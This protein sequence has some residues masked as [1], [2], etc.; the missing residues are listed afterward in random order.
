MCIGHFPI[1]KYIDRP[2]QSKD[3]NDC[4]SLL[5]DRFMYDEERLRDL[6]AM[7]LDILNRAVG[8]SRVLIDEDDASRVAAFGLQV[9]ISDE[10]AERFWSG[11]EPFVGSQMLDLWKAGASPFLDEAGIARANAGQGVNLLTTHV[12]FRDESV[13][14]RNA[15]SASWMKDVIG[16]HVRSL[17]TEIIDPAD[18]LDIMVRQLG[19]NARRYD[20]K[21]LARFP[22]PEGRSVQLIG[23][24]AQTLHDDP[25]N[26]AVS[27][28]VFNF[29]P[30]VFGFDSR[31]RRLLKLALHNG[32]TDERVAD[33]LGYS[34]PGVRKQ[35]QG[36]YSRILE[37]NAKAIPELSLE[38][39]GQ[40]RRGG[41]IRRHVLSFMQDHPEELH[42]FVAVS[43]SI[44]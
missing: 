9:F 33:M 13:E 27:N 19:M 3:L 35:W 23:I 5:Q 40:G 36:I 21:V 29:R 26:F 4:L 24:F 28:M 30:P 10:Q 37:V 39:H 1:M 38:T 20:D 14:L 6:S 8:H 32:Y 2:T 16:L 34:L 12:G 7:W 43:K 15:V 25:R 41:E 42:P 18:I 31:Q 11:S 44:I 22:I 17:T